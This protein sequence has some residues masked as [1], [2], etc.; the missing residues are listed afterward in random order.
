MKCLELWED[1]INTGL[2]KVG[3]GHGLVRSVSGQE[4]VAGTCVC[5]NELSG[6]IKCG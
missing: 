4:Q 5:G 6:F 1:N 3:W 2:E